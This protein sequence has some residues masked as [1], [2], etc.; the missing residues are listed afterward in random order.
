MATDVRICVQTAGGGSRLEPTSL[1][2][3][4]RGHRRSLVVTVRTLLARIMANIGPTGG[5]PLF[6]WGSDA[7]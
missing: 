4:L 5:R 7:I 2:P 3:G 6:G 1:L